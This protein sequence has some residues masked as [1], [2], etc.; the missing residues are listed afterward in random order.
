MSINKKQVLEKKSGLGRGL[1]SLLSNSITSIQNSQKIELKQNFKNKKAKK[2]STNSDIEN[3][4]YVEIPIDKIILN[5][6]QPRQ[7][8]SKEGLDELVQSI[9][10][11]GVIVPI[12]VVPSRQLDGNYILVAG[13]RRLQASKLAGL[14]YIPAI[15]KQLDDLGIAEL[16]LIENVHR[17][18]L[19][20][21]DE[22]YAYLRLIQ[23]FN[24]NIAEIS[25]KVGK[26]VNYVENKIKLTK[27][28]KIV[29]NSISMSEITEGHG[30]ALAYLN[31]EEAIVAA[32]KVVVR[33]KLNVKRTEDL[34]KDIKA[35]GG[36]SVRGLGYHKTVEWLNNFSYVREGLKEFLGSDVRLKRHKGEGGSLIIT[37][38]NDAELDD[39]YRKIKGESQ[40]S[41]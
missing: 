6:Y 32:F 28:P 2:K 3:N 25:K 9:K 1:S 41:G 26:S 4:K 19:N 34:V 38:Q 17:E 14:K 24:M 30:R 11:Y 10:L 13:E 36:R 39:I 29:Q 33:D 18:N 27:L 12:I 5:P 16:A 20:P 40:S 31:S 15:V 8:I 22:A 7:E 37:F 21:I 23:D 35:L